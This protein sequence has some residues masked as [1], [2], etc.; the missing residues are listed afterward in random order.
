MWYVMSFHP[1][2]L[3]CLFDLFVWEMGIHKRY[4]LVH[5][6]VCTYTY[7]LSG[8]M[9]KGHQPGSR[10]PIPFVFETR[11]VSLFWHNALSDHFSSMGL[12]SCIYRVYN[13]S[14]LPIL[15]V[16]T[17]WKLAAQL[18]VKPFPFSFIVLVHN[19]IMQSFI[20]STNRVLKSLPWKLV[21]ANY[22]I[23]RKL[24]MYISC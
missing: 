20:T 14:K 16:M 17:N 24:F 8:R 15:F 1:P 19:N 22:F 5:R 9:V 4:S 21:P 11:N 6:N 18:S 2:T 13:M 23:N 10:H 7:C 3:S 12:S